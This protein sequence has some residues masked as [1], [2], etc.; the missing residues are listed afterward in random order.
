MQEH[1]LK[2]GNLIGYHEL[3]EDMGVDEHYI[4]HI[5]DF[6]NDNDKEIAIIKKTLS[7]SDNDYKAI[8]IEEL[9]ASDYF[10]VLELEPKPFVKKYHNKSYSLVKICVMKNQYEVTLSEKSSDQVFED[11][12]ERIDCMFNEIN[13]VTRVIDKT[14]IYKVKWNGNKYSFK[15]IDII[16]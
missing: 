16:D 5:V 15:P 8:P 11:I 12:K 9:L 1:N 3:I 10:S 2:K 13:I 4:F 6:I 14:F 7:Y